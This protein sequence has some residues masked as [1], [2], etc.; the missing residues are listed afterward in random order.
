MNETRAES[1]LQL[2]DLLFAP[3]SDD[4]PPPRPEPRRVPSEELIRSITRPLFP[5]ADH[6]RPTIRGASAGGR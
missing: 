6:S 1:W 3:S 2:Q 4:T 5:V